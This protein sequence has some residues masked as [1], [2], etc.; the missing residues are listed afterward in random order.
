MEQY[1]IARLLPT[2]FQRTLADEEGLLAGRPN[3]LA[4][5]LAVM[6]Q[7]HAPAEQVLQELAHY[8][9]PDCV[10]AAFIPFLA[11]WVDKDILLDADGNFPAGMQRMRDLILA[12]VE[13]SKMRGTRVGLR[14]FLATATGL[15]KDQITITD[16]IEQPFHFIVTC[17][18]GDDKVKRLIVK[19]IE[20]EKPAYVTYE[21]SYDQ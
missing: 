13:L 1:K 20:L 18:N 10:H 9:D 2:I 5:L 19:I 3:T 16:S 8:F 7:L 21:I 15:K 12:S 6:E 17:P 4:A 14:D 11:Y